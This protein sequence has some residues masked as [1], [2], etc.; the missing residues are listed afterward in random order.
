LGIAKDQQF[1]QLNIVPVQY[2]PS[3]NTIRVYHNIEFEVVFV[4]G[5]KAAKRDLARPM[6]YQIV[7]HRGFE[8]VLQPFITWKTEMGFDVRVTYTDQFTGSGL[9]LSNNIRTY[10]QSRYNNPATRAHFLLLV[11]SHSLL[12]AF[13]TRFPVSSGHVTDFYFAEYTDDHLPDV[14][15]GRLSGTTVQHIANQI[16]KILRMEQL[17]IP[18]TEFMNRAMLIAGDDNHWQNLSNGQVN[19]AAHYYFNTAN[20]I[21]A[22]VLN[23]P[24]SVP[25]SLNVRNFVNT[26][27]SWVNFSAH[28]LPNG[29]YGPDFHVPHVAQLT[30][31]HMFPLMMGNCCQSG[32][33]NGTTSANSPSFGEALLRAE[34]RGAVAYIGTTNNSYWWEDFFWSLG[35]RSVNPVLNNIN[36]ARGG[37]LYS[38]AGQGAYDRMFHLHGEQWH[39][40]WTQSQWAH[41]VYEIIFAGNMAVQ[42]STASG[43]GDGR[44]KQYYWEI[45]TVFGDPSYIH[46]FRIPTPMTVNYPSSINT[47]EVE[48]TIETVPLA[49]IG[50]TRDGELI[51]GGMADLNGEVTFTFDSPLDL[52]ELKLVITARNRIP[53]FSTID[54]IPSIPEAPNA[55]TNFTVTPGA[56]GALTAALNWTNPALNLEDGALTG[57]TAVRIYLIGEE[58][59][60]H[61]ISNPPIGQPSSWT[62]TATASGMHR[63]RLVPENTYGEGRPANSAAVWIGIDVPNAPTNV[64]LVKNDVTAQLSWIAPT[65]S[66]NGGHFTTGLVYDVFRMP[67]DVQVATGLTT[68][69][70]S[71]VIGVPG[72]FSYRVLA[73]NATGASASVTSNAELFCPRV[74]VFPWTEGF[75]NNG[76]A[77]PFCWTQQHVLGA[78]NWTVVTHTIGSPTAVPPNGG[79]RKARFATIN[80]NGHT[81]KLI[82][83]PIDLTTVR[84]PVLTFWHTQQVWSSDQDALRVFY[85]TSSSSEWVL[86]QEYTTNIAT[87]TERII[88]LPNASTNFYIAFQATANFGHGVQ[89]DNISITGDPRQEGAVVATPE[90]DHVT[91]NSITILAVE[92]PDNGQPVEYAISLTLAVPRTGWQD[93]L[94]F[95]GLIHSTEYHIFARS[96]EHGP[97]DAGTASAPLT[98]STASDAT[99][100]HIIVDEQTLSVFPNPVKDVLHIQT[101]ET[102]QQIVVLDLNGRTVGT[103]Q[104]NHK[105]INLQSLPTGQY[106]VRIHTETAIV[107]I[108][109][110]KQ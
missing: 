33:L 61:T 106:I 87:W 85:R 7:S 91:Q 58:T 99:T 38:H 4:G 83:P 51:A 88:P 75:E 104:G 65:T 63:F 76:T 12:P 108:K 89:L 94:T 107:P 19:Y 82:S 62:Y 74:S 24:E 102:I 41:T 53:Y 5:Q 79:I 66:Q 48:L 109:I 37:I 45:Y 90:L 25:Q 98:A 46:S 21:N 72:T 84:N 67:G 93:E 97:F 35:A 68:T 1:A 105:S 31:T 57:L 64:V 29:W 110:M 13:P 92:A 103:W 22:T 10:L 32:W 86:L 77:L 95:D 54:I 55:A 2:L 73:R 100:I 101:D 16:D 23:F 60:V 3:E 49:R 20:G 43:S 50:L 81:T 15:I 17:D 69:T 8:T 56:N 78:V 34:N 42:L 96:K 26:G 27:A 71:E 30:N 18:S 36:P 14:Q 11:G 6:I 59:P 40:N 52:G 9:T 39:A 47:A 80:R 70:F 28:C 44:M